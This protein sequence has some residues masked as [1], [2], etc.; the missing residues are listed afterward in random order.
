MSNMKEIYEKIEDVWKSRLKNVSQDE[1]YIRQAEFFCGAMATLHILGYEAG[2]A[3][4]PRW[5][6]P[7]M[8]G[9]GV[10]EKEPTEQE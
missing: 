4:P 8:I 6:I 1:E 7:C 3:M 9:E 2:D 5:V 10:I